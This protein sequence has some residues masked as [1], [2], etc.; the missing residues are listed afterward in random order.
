MDA[1]WRYG[2]R[3]IF[4]TW[5]YFRMRSNNRGWTV[6]LGW[7]WWR[8]GYRVCAPIHRAGP[9]PWPAGGSPLLVA[10]GTPLSLEVVVGLLR[11]G[12]VCSCVCS[13]VC[14]ARGSLKK[15]EKLKGIN[16]YFPGYLFTLRYQLFNILYVYEFLF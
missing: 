11:R 3:N 4:K 16:I 6:L 12:M 2:R 10:G 8:R 9:V 1:M 5:R 14:R 7:R 13:A 15:D